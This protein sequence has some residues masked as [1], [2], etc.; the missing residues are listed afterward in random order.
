MQS[1][2]DAEPN[3]QDFHFVDQTYHSAACRAYAL[4]S[5]V[6]V[7]LKMSNMRLILLVQTVNSF[8]GQISNKNMAILFQSI[9]T[10]I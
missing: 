5:N 4:R 7:T 3:N 10:A 1:S 2:H 9:T 6:K 8:Y